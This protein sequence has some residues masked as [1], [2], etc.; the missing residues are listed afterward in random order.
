MTQLDERLARAKAYLKI[1]ES[2]D[3]KRE[4]YKA[5]ATEIAAY[6]EATGCTWP[7]LASTLR[8]SDQ[9]LRRIDRWRRSGFK[10]ETPFLM[11]TEATTRAARSHAKALL[12]D[13]DEAAKLVKGLPGPAKKALADAVAADPDT[14]RAVQDAEMARTRQPGPRVES[15]KYPLLHRIEGDRVRLLDVATTMVGHWHDG[16]HDLSDEEETLVRDSMAQAVIEVES[17]ITTALRGS[18]TEEEVR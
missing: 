7:V 6:K 15:V 12:A 8:R 17:T 5:A 4:A 16:R 9:T 10:A 1:A 13:P 3:S 2:N 18:H 11:D 14:S